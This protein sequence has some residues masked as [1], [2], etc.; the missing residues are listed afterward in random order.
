MP[1]TQT[2]KLKRSEAAANGG[3]APLG[4][5]PMPAPAGSAP[6]TSPGGPFART[7]TGSQPAVRVAGP[8]TPP[9]ARAPSPGARGTRG[10]P[11]TTPAEGTPSSEGWA[12]ER[13]AKDVYGF[14]S[15]FT[16]GVQRGLDE[17]Q[18]AAPPPPPPADN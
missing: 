9:P 15:E 17:S 5:A 3:A 6:R 13:S 8:S 11:G 2:V 4:R 18:P 12:S 16:A 7:P 14:L 10:A 1:N